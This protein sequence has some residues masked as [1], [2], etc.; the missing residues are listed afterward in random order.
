M[1]QV[2]DLKHNEISYQL[3]DSELQLLVS[4][5]LEPQMQSVVVVGNLV[6]SCMFSSIRSRVVFVRAA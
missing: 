1:K 3:T 2:S 4:F 6:L 5:G